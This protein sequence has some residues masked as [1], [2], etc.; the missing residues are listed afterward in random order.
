MDCPFSVPVRTS[1][2]ARRA[3]TVVGNSP[4]RRFKNQ[5]AG[6]DRPLAEDVMAR[7][8]NMPDDEFRRL[9]GMSPEPQ[10]DLPR[11]MVAGQSRLRPVLSRLYPRPASETLAAPP[12][13]L[14]SESSNIFVVAEEGQPRR[15]NLPTADSREMLK[16]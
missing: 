14:D 3:I 10:L 2:T 15:Y 4:F 6:T 1:T 12:I 11:S 9:F 16:T 8:Q 5:K 13:A 7:V